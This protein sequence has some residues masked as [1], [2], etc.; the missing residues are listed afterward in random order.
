MYSTCTIEPE[1]NTAQIARFLKE[2]PNYELDRA[3]NYLPEALCKDGFM[4]MFPH[5]HQTDGA[6]AARLVRKS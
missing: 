6:F 1:E 2:F 3:E 4:Q 5:V